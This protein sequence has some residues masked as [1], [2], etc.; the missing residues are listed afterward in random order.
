MRKVSSKRTRANRTQ[1]SKVL[2]HHRAHSD[3]TQEAGNEEH[4]ASSNNGDSGPRRHTDTSGL[5]GPVL[6]QAVQNRGQAVQSSGALRLDGVQ[7]TRSS[8]VQGHLLGDVVKQQLELVPSP[9]KQR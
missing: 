7:V 8:Q 9:L 2:G 4:D 3:T 1:S 6:R 5:P